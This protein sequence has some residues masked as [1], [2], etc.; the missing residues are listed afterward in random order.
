MAKVLRYP[1]AWL[2]VDHGKHV[3][4]L[5]TALGYKLDDAQK[6]SNGIEGDTSMVMDLIEEYPEHLEYLGNHK[7]DEK[8]VIHVKECP[9]VRRRHEHSD[10]SFLVY[11]SGSIRYK[12]FADSC[13]GQGLGSLLRLLRE[14]TGRES[15]VFRAD[16][17]L[18]ERE[19]ELWGDIEPETCTIES[20]PDTPAPTVEVTPTPV[21]ETVMSATPEVTAQSAESIESETIRTLRII[22]AQSPRSIPEVIKAINW[23][24]LNV[25]SDPEK[26]GLTFNDISTTYR[27]RVLKDMDRA[28]SPADREDIRL[29][30]IRTIEVRDIREMGRHLGKY[31]LAAIAAN[32][33]TRPPV[34]E[35]AVS[36]TVLFAI[37]EDDFS[38][39]DRADGGAK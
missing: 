27:R 30:Y 21:K 10:S 39:L 6:S 2:P 8:V 28:A 24:K 1:Q 9:F 37:L 31:W 19:I 3:Y 23:T 4:K 36:P 34:P 32:K 22:N 11:N 35:G 14:R 38:A 7:D 12:C 15:E 20:T 13:P 16:R 17:P 25:T 18:T 33:Q 5:A 26:W 29:R